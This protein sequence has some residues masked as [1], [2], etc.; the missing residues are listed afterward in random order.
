MLP[1]A[2]A[3]TFDVAY[4]F[5]EYRAFVLAHVRQVKGISPGYF[6]RALISGVAAIQFARKKRKMPS[7][8]FRI[9]DDGI[10]RATRLGSLVVPWRNVTSIYRYE[11]GYLVERGKGALPIPYR[12]ISEQQRMRL[13][14]LFRRRES[15]LAVATPTSID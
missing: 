9:D 15:E 6:S 10:T 4:R 14:Q 2:Q 1:D 3:V 12:C 13:E 11:P 5:G 8:S 7:C